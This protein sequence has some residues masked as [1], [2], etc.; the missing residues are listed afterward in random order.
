MDTLLRHSAVRWISRLVLGVIFVVASIEKISAPDIFAANIQ[1][2][3]I[4]PLPCINIVALIV[5]WIELICGIALLM[6]V[7][8]TAAAG[9]VSSMLVVFIAAILMAMAKNL[10][11]DCGCFGSTNATPVGWPKV[12]EDV[13]MLL[14]GL[15]LYFYS[16]PKNIAAPG[17][18]NPKI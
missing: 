7:R 16:E 11:I 1:A 15:H 8:V 3:H 9:L 2:Y 13:G 4:L 14:L 5:P 12:M 6:G 17:E 10:N 18:V